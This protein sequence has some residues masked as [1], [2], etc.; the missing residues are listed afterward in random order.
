MSR[1]QHPRTPL[2]N[3][4]S[5]AASE[6]EGLRATMLVAKFCFLSDAAVTQQF[7]PAMRITMCLAFAQRRFLGFDDRFEQ[8]VK[9]R[10]LAGLDVHRSDHAGQD[11]QT[12]RM[13]AGP[14]LPGAH[15]NL[16]IG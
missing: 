9:D 16:V 3:N 11:R 10:L 12:L 5:F 7:T 1:R 14:V 6:T 13:C 2:L 15:S 4:V 8:I